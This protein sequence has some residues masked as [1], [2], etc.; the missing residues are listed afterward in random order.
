[1]RET[2]QMI[3]VIASTARLSPGVCPSGV[4]DRPVFKGVRAMNDLNIHRSILMETLLMHQ[5]QTL[6]W[7]QGRDVSLVRR[8]AQPPIPLQA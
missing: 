3:M 8:H 4:A 5:R 7:G 6:A 1:M 2:L